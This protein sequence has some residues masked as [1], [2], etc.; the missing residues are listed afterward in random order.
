MS[1]LSL[2][3][4]HC[5]DV[6]RL[7]GQTAVLVRVYTDRPLLLLDKSQPETKLCWNCLVRGQ[8]VHNCIEASMSVCVWVGVAVS[9]CYIF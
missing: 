1:L 8:K 6:L 4:S 2:S 9:M 3:A 5:G 7:A